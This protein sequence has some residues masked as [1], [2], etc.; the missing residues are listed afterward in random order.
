[1]RRLFERCERRMNEEYGG[2]KT[3][4]EPASHTEYIEKILRGI[5][6]KYATS[7]ASR[8]SGTYTDNP[9]YDAPSTNIVWSLPNGYVKLSI[10]SDLTA[11]GAP[12]KTLRAFI[13]PAYANRP[14]TKV[15]EIAKALKGELEAGDTDSSADAEELI[16]TV[17]KAFAEFEKEYAKP[18]KARMPTPVPVLSFNTEEDMRFWKAAVAVGGTASSSNVILKI[19]GAEISIHN[20]GY[21]GGSVNIYTKDEMLDNHLVRLNVAERAFLRVMQQHGWLKS[22]YVREM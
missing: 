21:Y 20:Q 16:A 15:T 11:G 17:K 3:V 2:K 18:Q 5:G 4:R 14:M 7:Y 12:L 19:S 10:E 22:G 8:T 9:P 6:K 1:M 13:E